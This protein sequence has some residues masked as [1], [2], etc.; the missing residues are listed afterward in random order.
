MNRAVAARSGRA[1]VPMK[2]ELETFLDVVR[3][4]P[5]VSVDLVVRNERDEVLVGLRNNRPAKDRW[6]VPGGRICKDERIRD[7]LLR[8]SREEL[9][10]DVSIDDAVFLGVHEHLYDDNVGG[11]EGFGTHYV[12]LA[13]TVRVVV[14][15]LDLERSQHREYRWCAPSELLADPGVHE[16]TKAYFRS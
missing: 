5:L 2:L 3:H 12:V 9:G 1:R 6:F 10:V 7:A 16:N 8:V 11:V 13:Y 4:T 15:S 14:E